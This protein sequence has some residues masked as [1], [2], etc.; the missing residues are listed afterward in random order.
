M[1]GKVARRYECAV[2]RGWMKVAAY[3]AEDFYKRFGIDV[4]DYLMQ[5]YY[6]R[7]WLV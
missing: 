3:I 5:D 2:N 4:E 1:A 7:G 6:E